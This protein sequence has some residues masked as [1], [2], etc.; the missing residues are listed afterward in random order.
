M[1][2]K[3]E[4]LVLV[5]RTQPAAGAAPDTPISDEEWRKREQFRLKMIEARV[6][7]KLMRDRT[8]ALREALERYRARRESIRA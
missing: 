6:K 4:P 8:A 1:T 3:F 7:L 5:D 2:A